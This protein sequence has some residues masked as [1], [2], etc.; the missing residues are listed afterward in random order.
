MTAQLGEAEILRCRRKARLTGAGRT[1]GPAGSAP[2]AADERRE[3]AG[4]ARAAG[5]AAGP[6]LRR[7]QPAAPG[8]D[9]RDRAGSRRQSG[10]RGSPDTTRPQAGPP[11]RPVTRPAGKRR[12]KG[13]K[14]TGS[15]G[16]P[17]GSS[18]PG[19][20]TAGRP[21]RY[22]S[23]RVPSA[24]QLGTRSARHGSNAPR[25]R[26]GPAAPAHWGSGGPAAAGRL[27]ARRGG[28]GVPRSET[29]C[30]RPSSGP[31]R[32]RGRL[33]TAECCWKQRHRIN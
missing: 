21:S 14:E 6:G 27:R 7:A 20:A 19:E 23:A 3:A 9:H 1:G 18:R 5:P 16:Q 8:A 22:L 30:A 33:G 17:G 32:R 15:G 24:A 31:F 2:T 10:S 25:A 11:Q 4:P 26:P 29:G 12:G 13:R 28:G